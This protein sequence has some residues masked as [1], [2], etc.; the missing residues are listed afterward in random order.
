M[1][2]WSNTLNPD[3]PGSNAGRGLKRWQQAGTH[4]CPLDSP[5]SNAGRGLKHTTPLN[6]TVRLWIRPAAMPG[7]D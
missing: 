7:V 6:V 5:G 2:K 4:Y 1:V 3:S